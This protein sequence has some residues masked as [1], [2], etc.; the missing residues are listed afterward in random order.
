MSNIKMRPFDMANYLGT[1]EEIVEYLRQ[2]LEDN[3]PAE[4]A[5]ALGDIARARGMTQLARDTGLSRESLYKSLSGE[6]AP[7][8]ETLFKVIQ[9]M[10]F[11]LTIAP[12]ASQ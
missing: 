1:E 9:A 10:G 7:S 3:D 4:L 6:R 11:R 8:S 12:A 5:A 2:A